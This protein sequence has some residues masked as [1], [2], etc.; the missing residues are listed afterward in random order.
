MVYNGVVASVSVQ[1]V[2]GKV[3]SENIGFVSKVK[4]DDNEWTIIFTHCMIHRKALVATK[5]SHDL[6]DVLCDAIKIIHFIKSQTLNSRLFWN[7]FKDMNSDYQILLLRP[8]V[9]WLSR[10]RRLYTLLQLTDEVVI[11]SVQ[12]GRY[13]HLL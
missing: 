4:S 1:T 7:F 6:N 13:N 10:G 8:E 11:S 3:V 5:I 9:R 12:K 2:V